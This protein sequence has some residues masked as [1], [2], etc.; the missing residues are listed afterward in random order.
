MTYASGLTVVASATE[1][2]IGFG[3]SS[4]GAGGTLSSG[5]SSEGRVLVI[6][7][8]TA[9]GMG[10]GTVGGADFARAANRI[11]ATERLDAP[12]QAALAKALPSVPGY[13]TFSVTYVIEH[14]LPGTQNFRV[15]FSRQGY[16]RAAKL[17]TRLQA[18]L[19]VVDRSNF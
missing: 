5:G 13:G 4:D 12:S 8:S 10:P 9:K 7:N 1:G 16:R 3:G 6:Y 11:E 14:G 18:R 19:V 17:G 2:P 15:Y